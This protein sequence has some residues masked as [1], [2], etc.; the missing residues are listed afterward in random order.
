M[1]LQLSRVRASQLAIMGQLL[2]AERPKTILETVRG[3]NR[4]QIDPTAVV[5]RTEHLV[6]YSRLGAFDRAE[7][8]RLMYK[9]RKLFEY[10]AFIC[11]MSD[12]P[13]YR[14][15]MER[16]RRKQN[17]WRNY[18]VRW[19]DANAGFRRSVL[20]QLARG[21][22]P[23]SQIVDSAK[24]GY[25]SS[26]WNKEKNVSRMLEGLVS[27]GDV[28]IVGR[29]GQERIWG[30]GKD[31]YPKGTK[32]ASASQVTR[33]VLLRRLAVQGIARAKSLGSSFDVPDGWE[34]ALDALVREGEA[35]EVTVEGVKGNF[36][37][38]PALLERK[39]RGRS[40][41]LSPFDRL[42]H[43]RVRAKELF[44]LDYTLEIYVPPA[45]RR[46]GYY[47]LPVLQGDR[48][49]ARFDARREPETGT[50]RVLA[51]HS[52][53]GSTPDDARTVAREVRF[54]GRWLGLRNIEYDKV[55]RGWR[56]ALET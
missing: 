18:L 23:S 10:F 31:W 28:A 21:P 44:G 54:L 32:R 52:E 15:T 1:T 55:P 7:L 30:L 6:L 9:D 27:T 46:W 40:A 47:V 4:V 42:I 11:P 49:I 48:F 29:D 56:K 26:G 43:D 12:L 34:N 16:V 8:E 22:R 3:L 36:Y 35:R 33:E 38:S 51:L 39:F 13:I 25:V 53:K 5:A 2:D 37:T 14:H 19:M 20:K 50:L 24:S 17:Y 41:V 45:K